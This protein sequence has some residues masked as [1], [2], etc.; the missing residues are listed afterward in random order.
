[1]PSVGTVFDL[2]DFDDLGFHDCYVYGL[3]WEGQSHA[4]IVDLDYIVQW[5]KKKDKYCFLVA[6]AEARFSPVAGIR[7]SLDW[8]RL[9]L[10]C[11]IH[12]II[13]ERSRDSRHRKNWYLWTI[14]FSIPS[15]YIT[16]ESPCFELKILSD[17]QETWNQHLR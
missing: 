12:D 6:R 13:R 4:L 14:I 3:R 5:I 2:N 15:G 11:Q 17:P 16:F 7:I 1:M 10:E 8:Q 9:P